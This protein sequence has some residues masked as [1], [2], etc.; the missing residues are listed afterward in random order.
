MLKFYVSRETRL[1]RA[2][3]P[4]NNVP[5]ET[6]LRRANA[7]I[8]NVPRETRLRRA[9][10]PMNI[11]SRETH[12]LN[13]KRAIRESPLQYKNLNDSVPRETCTH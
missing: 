10:T 1:R 4:I 9:N 13:K 7:L 3:A 6:R 8:N 11:V 2:N 5:R 12:V